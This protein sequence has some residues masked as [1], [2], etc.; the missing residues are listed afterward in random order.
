MSS[1]S[2]LEDRLLLE[3]AKD[4]L[5][6]ARGQSFGH[7]ARAAL[8]CRCRPRAISPPSPYGRGVVPGMSYRRKF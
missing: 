5:E 6:M 7:L 1:S 8:V 3:D 2:L 4:F